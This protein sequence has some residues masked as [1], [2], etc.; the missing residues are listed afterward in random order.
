MAR[1]EQY[2]VDMKFNGDISQLQ[3]QLKNLQVGLTNLT[4][5]NT[6]DMSITKEMREASKAAAEMKQHLASA[7]NMKTGSL[8]LSKLSASLKASGKDLA[9][10]MNAF[11]QGGARGQK[12]FNDMAKAIT[13]AH[14][15]MRTS[16]KLL[17]SMWTTL[18]NVA[19][20]QIS[21]SIFTGFI[22]SI[23]Q[24]ITYLKTMDEEM[25]K[26]KMVSD[27]SN[28]GMAKFS[29][30]LRK[31]AKELKVA[32][33][34]MARASLIFLQQGDSAD[35]ALEKAIIVIKAAKVAGVATEE[36]SENLTA[37]WNSFQVGEDQ[38]EA[39]TDKLVALGAKTATSFSELSTAVTKVGATANAVG[40]NIDQLGATIA[41]I[42]SV[43]RESAE[44]TGTALKTIYARMGDLELG[45]TLEDGVT[46]GKVS[47]ALK[48]IGVDVLDANGALRDMG[49]V[50][51]EM[52]GKWKD[53]TKE[54]QVAIAEV[55]GGKRQY[56]QLLALFDNFDEYELNLKIS[57]DDSEGAVDE[58]YDEWAK[59]WAAASSEVK[60][61]LQGL[62]E[63]LFK[64]DGFIELTKFFGDLIDILEDVVNSFGGLGGIVNSLGGIFLSVFSQKI[65]NS[66]NQ[67]VINFQNFLGISQKTDIDLRKQ[68]NTILSLLSG[69]EGLS[70]KRQL[71]YQNLQQINE[72]SI[73]Y[74]KNMKNMSKV[75]RE[76]FQNGL[77][78]L[79]DYL[80]ALK[81]LELEMD[82]IKNKDIIGDSLT[83]PE[84][85]GE[86]T[87]T[88]TMLRE[89]DNGDTSTFE[90]GTKLQNLSSEQIEEY[91]KQ[92]EE[93]MSVDVPI[94]I[95][96]KNR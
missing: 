89:E 47:S 50:V 90:I 66:V 73:Y 84:G 18:K 54:Q 4:K 43:T 16:N 56:T 57:A 72:L 36:M 31:A 27:L 78:E 93:N 94:R 38:L 14:L 85:G 96:K 68:L 77:N 23:R 52:G 40:V 7:I 6:S 86:L 5:I 87:T 83:S 24:A 10:Y 60:N 41:T 63:S 67:A 32:N 12:T 92:I 55:M 59:S 91:K 61:S 88:K 39:Y 1:R 46:L 8:D 28:S 22:N 37:L 51:E 26:I 81:E 17:D 30:D 79:A 75:Q 76:A 25:T 82:K 34:E 3:Q 13:S 42:S 58:Q 9:H 45:E 15:P 48:T 49:T 20:Y 33:D 64:T 69:V 29:E 95:D 80:E 2:V 19:K 35:L 21:T 74:N 44:T 71:E 53:L 70:K 62:Y 11:A 65:G